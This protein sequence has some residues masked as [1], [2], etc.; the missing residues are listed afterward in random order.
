[1]ARVK[2]LSNRKRKAQRKVAPKPVRLILQER[3]PVATRPSGAALASENRDWLVTEERRRA[4]AAVA[5]DAQEGDGEAQAL[6][7]DDAEGCDAARDLIG[8]G[9]EVGYHQEDGI[10]G[11]PLRASSRD[12][13]IALRKSGALTDVQ[14]KAGLAF[15]LCYEGLSKGVGSGLGNAGEGRGAR[16]WAELMVGVSEDGELGLVK[17]AL[18]LHRQYLLVRLNQMERAASAHLV[19]GRELHA[20]RTIAG[21]GYTVREVA[22]SSGHARSVTVLA[23]GRALDAIAKVLRITGQ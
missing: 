6:L 14:T 17:G 3:A 7:Q 2:P 20:L 23:L 19:D 13:L 18:N 16:N 5:I 11:R 10:Q 4:M 22:G 8:V 12:G 1:M 21:E 9:F 15:R